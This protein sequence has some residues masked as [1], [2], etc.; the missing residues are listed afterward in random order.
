MSSGTVA[1][2]PL[3]LGGFTAV[4]KDSTGPEALEIIGQE[5]ARPD[6][7]VPVEI[8]AWAPG[9][10]EDRL[11]ADVCHLDVTKDFTRSRAED[12]IAEAT[13]K[14][15]KVVALG[16]Y[17]NPLDPDPSISGPAITQ[18][19]NVITA[20][21]LFNECGQDT[22]YSGFIGGDSSLDAD[23]NIPGFRKVW[24]DDLI[25]FLK[26]HNAKMGAE[27][28]QMDFGPAQ[29][30]RGIN[31]FNCPRVFDIVFNE[32]DCEALGLTPD[33][34][35]AAREGQDPAYV[36][37]KYAGRVYHL[38]LKDA[39]VDQ[40]RLD[41][42]GRKGYSL[43]YHTPV[44]PGYGAVNFAE[45]IRTARQLGIRRGVVEVEDRRWEK[46]TLFA[47]NTEAAR[48]AFRVSNNYL[49]MLCYV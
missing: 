28:C 31:F 48:D 1:L 18:I 34:A 7:L 9:S 24:G 27:P 15:T 16:Y 49:K 11:Y 47:T 25:P 8:A 30:K 5:F 3:L 42:N 26:D 37:K 12:F 13:A 39:R 19:K 33:P 45:Y 29:G 22:V 10:E 44:L 23:D 6:T 20:V 14:G 46:G 21:S 43:D 35:H 32:A 38:H 40:D 41:H 2:P 36:L 17:G 4:L